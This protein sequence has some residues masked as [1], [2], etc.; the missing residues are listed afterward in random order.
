MA[1][2]GTA[3]AAAIFGRLGEVLPADR[4]VL[5]GAFEPALG[6]RLGRA[7]APGAAPPAV[8]VTPE[9]VAELAMVVQVAAQNRWRLLPCGA[10]TK[11][12]WGTVTTGIDVLV[13]CDHL[14]ELV[15]WAVGDLTVTAAAGMTLAALQDK[16]ATA[17]QFLPIDPAFPDT[18]T[19]G[20]IVATADAGS[21]R[22]RYGGVRDLL[23]GLSFVRW[24]GAIAKAGGRVV[25]NVAGY[26]LMKLMTGSW[27]TLGIVSQVTFRT[28]ALPETSTTLVIRGDLGQLDQLARGLLASS[29]SPMAVDWLQEPGAIAIA[30]R[31]GSVAP[32]VT[33]Q[34]RRL[35]DSAT[36]L[37]LTWE[38]I[39]ADHET[40][41]WKTA[42]SQREAT[43]GGA[44]I[45]KVGLLPTAIAALLTETAKL[46]AISQIHASSGIGRL[47]IPVTDPAQV[48]ATIQTLRQRCQTSGG[49]LSIL[50]APA[51]VKGAIDPWGTVGNGRD[52][53]VQLKQQFD[54]HGLL[55]PGRFIV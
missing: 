54:P 37:G 45:L 27:G 28:Y 51:T 39:A 32:S 29:L 8:V 23:L 42:R 34:A 13:R 19:L 9:T 52:A 50:A 40:A 20:G 12:A 53:M 15:D 49:Y 22:H 38:A 43:Q 44:M 36:A 17:G 35:Q 2:Q 7:I 10:A 1:G 30:V 18:A 31:F 55:S 6:D 26:D 5:W 47:R 11:L 4:A 46:D 33:E 24:D 21:W 41:F 25:K 16:L 14:T 48:I 3:A